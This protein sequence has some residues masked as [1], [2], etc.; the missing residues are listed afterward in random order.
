MTVRPA[1]GRYCLGRSDAMRAPT[2]AAGM[3]AQKL[4]VRDEILFLAGELK[5]NRQPDKGFAF[6]LTLWTRHSTKNAVLTAHISFHFK[7]TSDY[8]KSANS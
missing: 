3:T 5:L 1:S 8:K 6:L 2:P 7:I 4:G